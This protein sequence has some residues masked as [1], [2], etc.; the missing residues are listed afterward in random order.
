MSS[1]SPAPGGG[2]LTLQRRSCAHTHTG[3]QLHANARTRARAQPINSLEPV[4]IP[5]LLS[6]IFSVT[7]ARVCPTQ[8]VQASVVTKAVEL[9]CSHFGSMSYNV[10]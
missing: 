3:T 9:I 1:A 7:L 4:G 6:C 5:M 2:F 8:D 10:S